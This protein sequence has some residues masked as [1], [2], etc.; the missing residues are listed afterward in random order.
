VIVSLRDDF[1]APQLWRRFSEPALAGLIFLSIAVALQGLG[2]AYGNDF[3][4]DEAAH[5]VS[6]VMLRDFLL[7]GEFSH[8][9][10]FAKSFY[11]HYPKVAIGQWPPVLYV[12]LGGWMVV[13]GAS[14]TAALVAIAMAAAATTT[15]I[16][17][18]GRPRAGRLPALL[19]G[20]VF[21][22]SPL[23]QQST[24]RVMTEHLV[25]LLALASAL[26]FARYT[27]TVQPADAWLFGI[28]AALAILTRGSAWALALVPGLTIL[29]TRRFDLLRCPSLWLSALPV[30]VTCVPWYLVTTGGVTT[31]WGA[32]SA[33]RH[34]G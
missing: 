12:V 4:N 27:R 21:L 18:V 7:G 23:V 26:Q 25:T 3:Y 2:G 28:L 32:L 14:R 1:R 13:F 30:L 6:A 17:L 10:A 9:M 16:Y 15:L 24:G 31:S 20:L 34:T 5:F 8:P 19:A 29:L 33:R 11:L 22:L